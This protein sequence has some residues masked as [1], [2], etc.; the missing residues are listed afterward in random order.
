[1]LLLLLWW[2]LL[3]LLVKP[4]LLTLP[5]TVGQWLLPHLLVAC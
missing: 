5:S 1:L 3:V 2:R 4:W